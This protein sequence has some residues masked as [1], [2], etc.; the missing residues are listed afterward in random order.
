MMTESNQA[1]I[2][3]IRLQLAALQP[4]FLSIQDDSDKHIGHEGAKHGA[5]HF[6]VEIQSKLFD[7]KSL[8]A[9]H[10]MVYS[11]LHSAMPHEIHA[12]KIIIRK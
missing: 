5:G 3:W 7:D 12:L 10:R 1:R 9:S 4:T 2:Q 11:V 6:T 8:V